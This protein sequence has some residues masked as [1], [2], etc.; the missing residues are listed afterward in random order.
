VEGRSC[1]TRVKFRLDEFGNFPTIQDMA[2]NLTVSLGRNI[3]WEL[4]VQELDQIKSKYNES[5]TNTIISNCQNKVY[6]K[7]TTMNTAETMSK[8]AGTKTVI[9]KNLSSERFDTSVKES[10]YIEK[11]K[12]IRTDELLNFVMGKKKIIRNLK[13]RDKSRKDIR[14]FPI[15]NTGKTQ[16]PRAFETIIEDFDT[17]KSLSRFSIPSKHR[18]LVLS[19]NAIDFK[20]MFNYNGG[21]IKSS[22]LSSD[23]Q[24]SPSK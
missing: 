15:L 4:Y 11:E 18:N 5:E 8:L 12:L 24:L 17:N 9:N 7:S 1:F 10:I 14:Q 23:I 16:M 21:K 3:L 13:S 2:E 22:N 6:I 19:D 20:A